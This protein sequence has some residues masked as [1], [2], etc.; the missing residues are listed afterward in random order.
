MT[1]RVSSTK[2]FRLQNASRALAH[3][4][5]ERHE[6]SLKRDRNPRKN[7]QA[8]SRYNKRYRL[9]AFVFAF[10]LWGSFVCFFVVCLAGFVAGLRAPIPFGR[11]CRG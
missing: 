2:Q 5:E 3:H 9:R 10:F 11:V 6:E 8:P 1:G 7:L 4:E